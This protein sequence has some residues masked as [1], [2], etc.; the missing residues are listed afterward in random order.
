MTGTR[1]IKAMTQEQTGMRVILAGGT[2]LVGGLAL[3]LL[4]A[5][6]AIAVVTSL[7]RRPSGRRHDKLREV[8]VDFTSPPALLAQSAGPAD[9]V[10]CA[11]GT[12]LKA[13]GGDTAAFQKVD[14]DY[15]VSVA[16][17]GR[18]AGASRFVGVSC[19]GASAGA[20]RFYLKTKGMA[21]EYVASLGYTSLHFLQPSLL[22]GARPAEVMAQ[23]PAE[24]W[25]QRLAPLL[26]L[27]CVGRFTRWHPIRARTV[28]KALVAAAKLDALG[29]GMRVHEYEAIRALAGE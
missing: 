10:L 27:A 22:L 11:L 24:T 29:A 1:G 2:G 17:A 8:V 26:G 3:E 18:L 28:A 19:A 9:A 25:A 15:V 7:T 13:V 14:V 20:A 12:T 16:K 23:R 6:P 4:L 21:E 5:D